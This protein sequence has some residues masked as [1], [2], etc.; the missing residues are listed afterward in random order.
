MNIKQLP[1]RQVQ[2]NSTMLHIGNSSRKKKLEIAKR[3]YNYRMDVKNRL[4][5]LYTDGI[6]TAR[7]K[8][9]LVDACSD[10]ENYLKEKDSTVKQE[11]SKMGD[12]VELLSDRLERIGR[13]KGREEGR[14]EGRTALLLEQINKKLAKGKDIATIA[15]ELEI[16]VATV[17]GILK[18]S[19]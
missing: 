8:D 16:D 6:L 11:V 15:D 14:E 4:E 17:E 19:E 7:E 10:V 9:A 1:F 3:L 12:D 2:L 5:K 18:L 13:E